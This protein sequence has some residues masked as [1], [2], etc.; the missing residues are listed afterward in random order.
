MRAA[1]RWRVLGVVRCG[2]GLSSRLRARAPP[3]K[4]LAA[5]THVAYTRFEVD[6]SIIDTL[7]GLRKKAG[8]GERGE[9]TAEYRHRGRLSGR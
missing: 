9:S 6:K 7:V 4:Y 8:A 1:R 3:V 5:V 2:T